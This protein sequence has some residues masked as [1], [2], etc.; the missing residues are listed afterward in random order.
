[1]RTGWLA[2]GRYWGS[3]TNKK[4]KRAVFAGR[5]VEAGLSGLESYCLFDREHRQIDTNMFKNLRCLEKGRATTRREGTHFR[6]IG[7]KTLFRRWRFILTAG[8]LTLRRVKWLQHI[9]HNKTA[10]RQ[11][12]A[13]VWGNLENEGP[14]IG[15]DGQLQAEC[16]PYVRF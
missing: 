11:I 12:R 3:N 5:V 13:A 9:A 15:E 2:M 14:T 1:M 6:S 8:E 16:N 7:L 4:H 10:N